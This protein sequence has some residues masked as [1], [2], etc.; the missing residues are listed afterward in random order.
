MREAFNT[1]KSMAG[2]AERCTYCEDSLGSS[3]DH[4][5]PRSL[6]PEEVF[7]WEN[8]ILACSPCNGAKLDHHAILLD[9][10][11][12][13]CARKQSDPIVP[14]PMGPMLLINPRV[15][16]PSWFMRLDLADTF[17]FTPVGDLDSLQVTRYEYTMDT[18]R[19]NFGVHPDR[20]SDAYWDFRD[21][22]Q[23]YIRD[24]DRG[25]STTHL[26][27]FRPRLLR[28]AHQ[29]VWRE[30]LR[31]MRERDA[32]VLRDFGELFEQAP[33][34]LEWGAALLTRA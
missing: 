3:I 22:L 11:R 25:M 20:R 6:Y 4:V 13:D 19:L 31:H 21:L 16:N 17:C 1:L 34:A 7:I 2:G 27:A 15:E 14:P 32:F 12:H 24:R 30:I 18:L 29:T 28:R 8:M 26:A 5:R 9:G 33:E 23:S 10:V